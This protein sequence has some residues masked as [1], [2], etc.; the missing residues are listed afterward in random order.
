[1]QKIDKLAHAAK[2]VALYLPPVVMSLIGLA[3]LS[4][5]KGGATVAGKRPT[6]R[7]RATH[8]MAGSARWSAT[9]VP[10]GQADR[11]RLLLRLQLVKAYNLLKVASRLFWN[12]LSPL[13]GPGG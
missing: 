4:R 8:R 9:A 1:M 5:K 13:L 11:Q 10:A 3:A 7:A 6:L 2:V 12:K